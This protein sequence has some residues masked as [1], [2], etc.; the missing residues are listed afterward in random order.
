MQTPLQ[1]L[2]FLGVFFL[3]ILL[4]D[5]ILKNFKIKRVCFCE[6]TFKETFVQVVP[7]SLKNIECIASE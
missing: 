4:C 7:G 5:L 1:A 6:M 2:V 3:Q